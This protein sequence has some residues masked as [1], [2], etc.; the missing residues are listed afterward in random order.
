[1]REMERSILSDRDKTRG[2]M[3]QTLEGEEDPYSWNKDML[4]KYWVRIL[5]R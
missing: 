3:L 2:Y 5:R 4:Q 1:M